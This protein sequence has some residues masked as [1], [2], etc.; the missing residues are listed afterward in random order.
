L[1]RTP[2]ENAAPWLRGRLA[3][4]A[5]IA[6]LVAAHL[7]WAEV[8][9]QD[10]AG[11]RIAVPAR[12]ERVFAPGPPASVLVFALAPDTLL[13]WN[14]PM[15]PEE[16]RF[17]PPRYAA[18][19]ALGR[20]TGRANTANVETVLRAKPDPILDVGSVGP[21][22]GSLADRVQSQTGIPYV[23]LDGRLEALPRTLELAG[24]LLGRVDRARQLAEYVRQVLDDVRTQVASVPEEQRPRV[25]YARGPNGLQTALPGSINAEA[26][27]FVGARN[28]AWA[29]VAAVRSRRVCLSPHLPFR[30]VNFPPRVNRVMGVRW[31]AAVPYP[32]RFPGDLRRET[33]AFYRVFY[34]QSPDPALL[35]PLLAP[36]RSPR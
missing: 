27:E 4:S 34:H 30:W 25:Y 15:T 32:H 1:T 5:W 8:T 36:Q 23:L 2:V 17:I 29:G 21:T 28:P 7:A 6:F 14:G 13:R 9:F 22:F 31:P 18:L 26:L 12:V 33:E 11:R 10:A 35:A 24:A 20:L 16:A 19:A 3:G